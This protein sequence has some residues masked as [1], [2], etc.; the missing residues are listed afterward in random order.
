[1]IVGVLS[2]THGELHPRVMPLFREA[3]VGIIL[4]AGDVGKYGIIEALRALAPLTAV[5]GNVDVEGRVALLPGEVL[6]EVEGVS[7]YMTHIG[8]KPHE[9][10][11][12]LPRPLPG[13]AIC[14]HSHVPLCERIGDTVFLNPGA[15]GTRPRFGKPLSAA[16]LRVSEGKAEAEIIL[17]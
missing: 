16:L 1:L 17:L 6:L 15:A 7:V 8:G 13:V 14:G 11:R 3:G 5:C 4:H 9:W 2:D 10:V 12:S